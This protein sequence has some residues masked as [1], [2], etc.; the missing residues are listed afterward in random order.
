SLRDLTA[1]GGMPGEAVDVRPVGEPRDLAAAT[2]AGG[3]GWTRPASWS[4][5]G[6]G[7][8][9]LYEFSAGGTRCW[10]TPLDGDG[11]GLA[12][13]VARWCRQI[14]HE[15]LSAER[16]A[17]LPTLEVLGQPARYVALLGDDR[18]EGL[19]GVIAPLAGRTLFVKMQGPSDELR[20]R[21]PEF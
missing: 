1:P 16:I 21:M 11:G 7:P 14:G 6:P 15:A 10:L 12:A 17:S 2:G 13:N 3:F 9:K 19:L 5:V 18:G 4:D 20:A 8:G